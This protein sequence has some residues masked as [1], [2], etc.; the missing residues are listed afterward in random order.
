MAEENLAVDEEVQTEEVNE[1]E[2]QNTETGEEGE[3]EE[4]ETGSEEEE[5]Q[6]GE[7]EEEQD[8]DSEDE[9]EE[10]VE[11]TESGYHSYEDPAL[12][13]AVSILEEAE[14]PVE[15]ANAIFQE[16]VDSND[17]SKINK[18]A[19]IEKLGQEKADLVMVLAEA[20]YTKTFN[21]MKAVK[22]KA[23][24][25]TGTE[26]QFNAMTEWAAEKAKTDKDF[27]KDLQEFRD[28]ID[29]GKPRA[30]KAAVRELY[31]LYVEDPDT[32]IEADL[33]VGD[34][35]ASLKGVEPMSRQDYVTEIEK[36]HR[37]GTYDKVSANLW[38]RRQAG[39]KKGI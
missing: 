28:M 29:S 7:S 38:K 31:D 26:E 17:L 34:K 12:K 3:V 30:I 18:N 35:A 6:E 13:Q 37:D 19:L 1:Q 24:E 4:Q 11:E 23:F 33:E 36:A 25:I 21:A 8:S 16:A 20:Y 10:E 9:Q 5:Q 27:A 32:T 15:E 2:T 14:I 39:I 22:D